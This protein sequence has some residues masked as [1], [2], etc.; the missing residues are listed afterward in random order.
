L[1]NKSIQLHQ[2]NPKDSAEAIRKNVEDG[3][4]REIFKAA[5]DSKIVGNFGMAQLTV[6]TAAMAMDTMPETGEW[7]DWVMQ[8]GVPDSV[9]CLGGNFMNQL[10]N[11]VDRNGMGNEASPGY[12][13]LWLTQLLGV[14]ELLSDYEAYP[15]VNLYKNPKFVNMFTSQLP[16]IMAGYYTAQIGDSGG[17]ASTE[18]ML[19]KDTA[20]TGFKRLGDPR[21][22]Q[23][24]YMANGNTVEGIHDIIT[25]KDPEKIKNDI[26]AC[27]N[28]Y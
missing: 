28:T 5:V 17:T 21:L 4:L 12:N 15:D 3:I 26:L 16:L 20:I 2:D 19:D 18:F 8:S 14:A 25:E 27:I 24:A 11:V 10:V 1:S 7:L 6:A 9:P 13:S 22:A 23:F